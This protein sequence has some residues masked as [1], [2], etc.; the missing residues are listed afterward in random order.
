MHLAR[1]VAFIR[2]LCAKGADI[3]KPATAILQWQA[4]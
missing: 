1:D 4:N 3:K 2:T